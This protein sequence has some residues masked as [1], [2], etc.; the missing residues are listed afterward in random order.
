MAL[1]LNFVNKKGVFV[2]VIGAFMF[3]IGEGLWYH[4]E[5]GI[6]WHGDWVKV[7]P[8]ESLGHDVY[9]AGFPVVI[10]GLLIFIFGFFIKSTRTR[11]QRTGPNG[12]D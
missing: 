4:E 11:R 5:A 2:I 1:S 7:R 9:V 12:A 10:L 8:Y 3:V 6:G